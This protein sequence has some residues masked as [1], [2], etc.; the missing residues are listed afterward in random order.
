[1]EKSMETLLNYQREAEERFRRYEDEKWKRE[2][3]LE[4]KRRREDQEHEMRVMGMLANML[5]QR[6]PQYRPRQDFEEESLFYSQQ[7]H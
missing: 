6:P 2:T 1:M 4:E 3:E 7:L 5:Q